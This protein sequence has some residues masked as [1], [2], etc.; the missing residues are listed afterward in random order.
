M[1]LLQSYV[2]YDSSASMQAHSQNFCAT[3]FII[4]ATDPRNPQWPSHRMIQSKESTDLVSTGG[5]HDE[6][7]F[8]LLQGIADGPE[9]LNK[10]PLECNL[11]HL[12]YIDFQKGCYIGQELT[13]R[14]K[15][16]VKL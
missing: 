14:T 5:A 6:L 11:D 3:D 16:K 4:A 10:I 15:Y 12:N 7:K 13:A 8:R 2:A 9:I 1:V